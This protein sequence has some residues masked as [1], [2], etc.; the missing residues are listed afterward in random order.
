M[1]GRAKWIAGRGTSEGG[2][3]GADIWR[4][5]T[6][7]WG[8]AGAREDS[9]DPLHMGTSFPPITKAFLECSWSI[10]ARAKKGPQRFRGCIR[11]WRTKGRIRNLVGFP[12]ICSSILGACPRIFMVLPLAAVPTDSCGTGSSWSGRSPNFLMVA[13]EMTFAKVFPLS[14]KATVGW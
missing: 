6:S 13:A 3:F 2:V 4:V 7:E 14:T 8:S 9:R 11:P 5:Q 10:P 12:P 1:V